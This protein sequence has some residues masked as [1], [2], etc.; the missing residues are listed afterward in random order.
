V[1]GI[2]FA[3]AEERDAAYKL[4]WDDSVRAASDHDTNA[5]RD[6]AALRYLRRR[7]RGATAR[8]VAR[9]VFGGS[10][11]TRTTE[12]SIA[13]A[14]LRRLEADGKVYRRSRLDAGNFHTTDTADL[15]KAIDPETARERE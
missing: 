9:D 6:A 13:H 4:L 8:D 5:G 15:W 12:R 7:S 11:N 10:G 1:P 2:L 3:S 14:T